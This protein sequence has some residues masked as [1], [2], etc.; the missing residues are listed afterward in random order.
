MSQIEPASAT[1]AGMDS[2]PRQPMRPASL[3]DPRGCPVSTFSTKALEHTETAQRRLLSY[4]GDP[5][6]ALDAAIAEDPGWS[7]PRVMKA[8]ALLTLAEHGWNELAA[9]CVDEALALTARYNERERAHLAATRLC[10]RGQWAQAC[11]AWERILVDHPQDLV[12]LL[13]A[14]LFDFY[15]GDSRNLQRRVTRV[16]PRWSKSAPLYSFVLGMHAFGL[17]EN[18][19]YQLAHE[20][21]EAALALDRRDPWAVHAVAHVHEMQGQFEAGSAWLQERTPDWAPENA[22]AF[23]NWWHLALFQLEQGNTAAAVSLLDEQVAPGAE[24]AVQRVDVTALMW[25]L[26][27]MGVDLGQRWQA[28][29]DAWPVRTQE[30]GFYAF[31]DLHAALAQIGAGRLDAVLE[32]TAA[33]QQRAQEQTITGMMAREVGL[34]LLQGMLAYAGEQ[35]VEAVGILWDVRD[36]LQRFGGSHAQRDL[37]EQTLLDT[38]IHAG[39]KNLALHLLGDRLLM[40]SRSPLTQYWAGRVERML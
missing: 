11:D 15:R 31:N 3:M 12:A 34:P 17:E 30:A 23:H 13:P 40:K 36:A 18:N 9:Q 35:H 24:L 2:R 14:H 21:G 7:L 27:L 39:E 25:R 5:I 4:F 26:R 38:A 8:N 6:E 22:F 37:V 32:L 33:V 19:H 29:A 1:F 28:N 10:L 16:L 20:T